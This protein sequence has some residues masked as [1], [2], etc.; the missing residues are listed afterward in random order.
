MWSLA[1]FADDV[2]IPLTTTQQ[3]SA[4]N[5]GIGRDERSLSFAPEASRNCW[6]VL[7]VVFVDVLTNTMVVLPLW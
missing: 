5:S 7:I 2:T 3:E 6:A 1:T 4:A